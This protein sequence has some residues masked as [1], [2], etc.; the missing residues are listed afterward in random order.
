MTGSVCSECADVCSVPGANNADACRVTGAQNV[1]LL[2]LVS[3]LLG[4]LLLQVCPA[5]CLLFVLRG[6]LLW[7]HVCAYLED[8]ASL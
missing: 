4:L 5:A 3:V 2:C 1:G 7:P 6:L 8:M